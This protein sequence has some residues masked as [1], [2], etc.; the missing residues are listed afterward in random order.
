MKWNKA[1]QKVPNLGIIDYTVQHAMKNQ[2]LIYFFRRGDGRLNH[3]L[4]MRF[5]EEWFQHGEERGQSGK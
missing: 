5:V 3:E 4:N 1:Q 2:G